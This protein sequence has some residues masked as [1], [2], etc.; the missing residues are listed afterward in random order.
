MSV[1][2]FNYVDSFTKRFE[3]KLQ[4]SLNLVGMF[5]NKREILVYN[6]HRMKQKNAVVPMCK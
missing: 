2:S 1:V 6:N 5:I 3:C 4:L